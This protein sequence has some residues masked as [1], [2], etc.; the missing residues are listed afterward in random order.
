MKDTLAQEIHRY[1]LNDRKNIPNA[2]KNDFLFVTHKSGPTQGQPLSKSGYKKVI[3]VV[4][5]AAP[6]LFNLAGH[7]LRHTWNDDF[8]NHMDAMDKPPSESDQEKLRSYLMGWREG[9]GTAAHYNKRFVR[10]KAHEAALNLQEGMI[11]VPEGVN[12]EN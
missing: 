9:S 7:K 12:N 6:S 5:K 8:S 3:E 10:K 2:K 11:R 4:R 1:I